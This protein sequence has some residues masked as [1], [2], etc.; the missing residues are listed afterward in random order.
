[1]AGTKSKSRYFT[2]N[3]VK[4]RDVNSLKKKNVVY[5]ILSSKSSSLW[6]IKQNAFPL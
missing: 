6:E 5:I 2:L 3:N 4:T 1:M